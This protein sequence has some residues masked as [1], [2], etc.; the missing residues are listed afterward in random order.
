MTTEMKQ[1]LEKE[2]KINI[3]FKFSD[4]IENKIVNWKKENIF[5]GVFPI[6]G[7]SM[8][9][10]DLTKSIPN[11]SKVLAFDLELNC[12]SGLSNIWHEIP[13]NEP[14]LIAG[15]QPIGNEF[16]V[17]KT[18]SRIEAVNNYILITSHNPT[19]ESQWIPFDWIKNIFKVV[20]I[21]K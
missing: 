19:F 5:F 11:N 16:F 12:S 17:C 3:D 14:L 13:T 4:A 18:I 21:I 1:K 10:D 7:D 20:Q 9:C 6:K 15:M 8:T 2:K